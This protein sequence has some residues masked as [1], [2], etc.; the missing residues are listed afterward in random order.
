MRR[1]VSYFLVQWDKEYERAEE[2]SSDRLVGEAVCSGGS[3]LSE[4]QGEGEG[5]LKEADDAEFC[6]AHL[7]A[8]QKADWRGGQ[9]G[10][11]SSRHT[12]LED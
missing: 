2:A 10:S 1:H 9:E 8:S 4:Q 7:T 12:Q 3:P 11:R 5:M 6:C